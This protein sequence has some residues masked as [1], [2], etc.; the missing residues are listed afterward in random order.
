MNN[1]FLLLVVLTI[2][3]PS[4]IMCVHSQNVRFRKSAKKAEAIC[5]K[6]SSMYTK[7][8]ENPGS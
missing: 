7:L 2:S 4:E 3:L 8:Y 5:N 1:K 6:I